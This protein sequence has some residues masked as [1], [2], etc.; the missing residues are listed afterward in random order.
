[1]ENSTSSSSLLYSVFFISD[2]YIRAYRFGESWRWLTHWFQGKHI[3][4]CLISW[5]TCI[6]RGEVFTAYIPYLL[7][8]KRGRDFRVAWHGLR[9]RHNCF[10]QGDAYI[11]T[12]LL[13]LGKF[14]HDF[15]VLSSSNRGR[16]VEYTIPVGKPKRTRIYDI[17]D[18]RGYEQH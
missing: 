15:F 6:T 10:I 8:T 11:S 4:M 1:M 9:G 16:L 7:I 2:H 13:R 14:V 17:S 3:M 18:L 5:S 12:S